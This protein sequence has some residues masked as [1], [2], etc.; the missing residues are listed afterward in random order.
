M[1]LLEHLSGERPFHRASR[2][3]K[4]RELVRSSFG[5]ITQARERGYSWSQIQYSMREIWPEACV[6]GRSSLIQRLYH[7][8]RKEKNNGK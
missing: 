4:L 3:E 6:S 5:E 8:I 1:G 2:Q 7:E